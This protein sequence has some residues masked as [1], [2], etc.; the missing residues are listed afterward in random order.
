[1]NKLKN[2][3]WNLRIIKDTKGQDLIEYALMAG[4]VAV[5]AGAIMP[6]VA[7]SIGTI[8]SKVSNTMSTAAAQGA[9]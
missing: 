1:M 8:F 9:S 5:A 3:V 6:G 2:L 7:T 4:F